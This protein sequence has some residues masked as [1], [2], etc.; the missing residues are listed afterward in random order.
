MRSLR[1]DKDWTQQYVADML[2]INRRT[3]GAYENGVNNTPPEILE[4]LADIYGTSVDFI[5]GRTD[6]P[7]P[8]SKKR[9]K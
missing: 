7:L 2:H 8:Y 1:E 6:C 3:Y 5:M 9:K 4:K